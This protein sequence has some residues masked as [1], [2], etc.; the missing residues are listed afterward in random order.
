MTADDKT[1]KS[2]EDPTQR[3]LRIQTEGLQDRVRTRTR[4]LRD[5]ADE[6]DRTAERMRTVG[7]PGFRGSELANS[8]TYLA[9][10]LV[11]DVANALPNLNLSE[12]V[13]TAHEIDMQRAEFKHGQD[14]ELPDGLPYGS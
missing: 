4:R 8:L 1:T 9:A 13:N 7:T 6:M 2:T 10:T 14:D 3:M 12:L 5:L 11:H